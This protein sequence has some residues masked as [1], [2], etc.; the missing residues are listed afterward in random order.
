MQPIEFH[1]K[2][3]LWL[4]LVFVVA[5]IAMVMP[6]VRGESEFSLFHLHNI[7]RYFV[8]TFTMA[9]IAAVLMWLPVINTKYSLD[10][11]N[12]IVRFGIFKWQIPFQ[13]IIR[14]EKTRDMSASPALSL[15]RLRIAYDIQGYSK[16]IMISPKNQTEFCSALTLKV[17]SLKREAPFLGCENSSNDQ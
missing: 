17:S 6:F 1:S 14:M 9:T 5:S 15:D 8:F 4:I 3:D 10:D 7:S 16:T 13:T 12:L 2:V 11:H